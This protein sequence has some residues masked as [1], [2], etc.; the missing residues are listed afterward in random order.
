MKDRQIF[1]MF[2]V[3]AI[4][5]VGGTSFVLPNGDP[6]PWDDVF[7]VM[8]LVGIVPLFGGFVRF[9]MRH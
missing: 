5:G 4:V 6:G 7:G 2:V 8:G 3:M 1:L 9:A